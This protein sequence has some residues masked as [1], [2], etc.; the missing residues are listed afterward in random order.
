MKNM[1]AYPL[2][3]RFSITIRD[4]KFYYHGDNR[5]VRAERTLVLE[6]T[7]ELMYRRANEEIDPRI[8]LQLTPFQTQVLSTHH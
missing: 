6:S 5:R 2:M 1:H 3:Q 7:G 4:V 8:C